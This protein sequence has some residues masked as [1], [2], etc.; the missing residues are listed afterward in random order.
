MIFINQKMLSKL[1]CNK[2][3]IFKLAMEFTDRD[4]RQKPLFSMAF[5]KYLQQSV[6]TGRFM[7]YHKEQ[8]N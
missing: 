8:E 7:R 5:K 1:L 6:Y 3:T 4:L 2:K